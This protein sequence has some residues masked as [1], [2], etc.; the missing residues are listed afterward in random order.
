MRILELHALVIDNVHPSMAKYCHS[1][2]NSF[3]DIV[4]IIAG[5]VPGLSHSSTMHG[6]KATKSPVS[7][8]ST[9]AG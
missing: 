2:G 7:L 5:N 6:L 3:S 1:G 9:T 4:R 8:T